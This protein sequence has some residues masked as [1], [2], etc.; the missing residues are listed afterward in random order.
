MN[1]EIDRAIEEFKVKREASTDEFVKKLEKDMNKLSL[2]L[3][4]GAGGLATVVIV[5]G[6]LC[7]GLN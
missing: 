4:S 5:I 1:L 2:I 3:A 7:R 6:Y